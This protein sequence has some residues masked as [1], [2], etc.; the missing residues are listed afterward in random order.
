MVLGIK[1]EKKLKKD[2]DRLEIKEKSLQRQVIGRTNLRA[3]KRNDER[4]TKRE[5]VNRKGGLFF[6]KPSEF[7]TFFKN[8]RE[9]VDKELSRLRREALE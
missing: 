8:G 7:K 4:R 2:L 3:L 9:E 5:I 1:S 6:D